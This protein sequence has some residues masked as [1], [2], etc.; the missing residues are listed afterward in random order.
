M[1]RSLT[2]EYKKNKLD[3]ISET[4]ESDSHYDA[5]PTTYYGELDPV[6]GAI[7][8]INSCVCGNKNVLCIHDVPPIEL[9]PGALNSGTAKP[10]Q[11]KKSYFVKCVECGKAGL[12]AKQNWRAILQWNKSPNSIHPDY[13]ELPLFGLR[14]LDCDEAKV[15][16]NGIRHD[17]ELRSSKAG[18]QLDLSQDTTKRGYIERMK[19]Y[20]A[21][22]I[23]AQAL[24]SESMKERN[25]RQRES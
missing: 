3:S 24:V 7:D 6:S 4:L 23:Y 10:Y 5:T 21:W 12:A 1:R 20:L 15:R 11:P 8:N 19:A 13:K 16:L 14:L 2:K 18:L 17:L 22:C 25:R 9:L